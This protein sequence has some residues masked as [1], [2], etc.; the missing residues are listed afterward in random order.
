MLGPS[1]S[2]AESKP[3]Q[4][5]EVPLE[6][7]Q[8]G[9]IMDVTDEADEA[10]MAMMGLAGFGTTKVRPYEVYTYGLGSL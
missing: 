10:M 4:D 5:S 9:E 3:R 1:A 7:G 8:E 2:G 6:D